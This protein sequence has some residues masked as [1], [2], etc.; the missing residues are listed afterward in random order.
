MSGAIFLWAAGMVAAFSPFIFVKE[1]G[2]A[3]DRKRARIRK[4]GLLLLLGSAVM[5]LNPF[6][7]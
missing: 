5:L 7:L 1:E 3:G 6:E 2:E 4:V